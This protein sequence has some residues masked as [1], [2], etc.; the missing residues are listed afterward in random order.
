MASLKSLGTQCKALDDNETRPRDCKLVVHAYA[1][2]LR[3]Y[4]AVRTLHQPQRE[5]PVHFLHHGLHCGTASPQRLAKSRMPMERVGAVH[6]ADR[7][8]HCGPRYAEML[9]DCNLLGERRI[10]S[11]RQRRDA[12]FAKHLPSAEDSLR[13][14]CVQTSAWWL[15]L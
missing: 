1:Q 10:A 12:V 9:H 4:V 3:W 14:C 11:V 6:Y 15:A 5:L 7:H 13:Q 8:G 2:I